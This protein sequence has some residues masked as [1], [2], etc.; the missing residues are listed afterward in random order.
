MAQIVASV[1]AESPQQVSRAAARAAMAGADWLELRLDRWPAGADL[2]PAIAQSRLPV[3]VACRTPDDGGAFR[4]TLAERRDLLQHA[5]NAGAQGIDL[6]GW[7]TWAPPP[8]HRLRLSIRSF[9]SF[10]GVPKELAEIRDR[11]LGRPG[12][13]AKVVVTSHD[14]ADAAPV[15]DLLA[16]TDQEARPTV[17]FAMGRTAWPVRLLACALGAPLVYGAL[18]AGAET[19]PGQIPV[20]LLAGL[21]RAKELNRG[22]AWLGLLGNPALSSLGPWLHNRACRR[23][24]VDAVYLPFETSRPDAV[25]AM[26]LRPQLRGLSVT[27][28][29]KGVLAPHC[30]QLDEAAAAIGVVNTIVVGPGGERIG[31]NTDVAGVE[32]ALRR[33]GTGDGE[34][35][36][37]VVLGTGG[38]ARAGAWAL[39]RMGFEV[40]LLGRS[41]EPAR[42]FAK[43]HGLQLGG[44]AA[45]VLDELRPAVVVHATPVGSIDRDPEER[46]VPDWTPVAGTIV[47]DMV[48][49]PRLTRLLRDAQAAGARTVAG[50]EMFLAQAAAQVRWFTGGALEVDT[51]RGFLAGSGVAPAA[52]LA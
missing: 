35:R 18:E 6:E 13:I 27:A 34:G 2:A 8:R 25:L 31:Y 16:Q 23:L 3:L 12:T 30:D 15:L 40:T 39:L 21:Y 47:L 51:L 1:F 9:H 43:A 4:G 38:A 41:L 29:F 17:A 14:L 10:T 46:L 24:G 22:T 45:R 19:A 32:Q 5:L 44:L 20:G 7:E 36:P 42:A 33:A 49:Q 48:Y 37:A 50:V 28:P 11:L 26:L 52:P